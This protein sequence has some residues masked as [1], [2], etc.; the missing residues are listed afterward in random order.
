MTDGLTLTPIG[1]VRSPFTDR[2]C[3]PRQPGVDG[4]SAEGRIVLARGRGFEQAVRDLAGIERIWVITWFHRNE[5]WKPMVL[6]PRG[7]RVKRGVFATR[8]P[9]R[10]NPLG[11]SLLPLR[12]VQGLTL[13]VGELD[14]LDGTPVFDVK[15]YL[16]YAEAFPDARAGWIDAMVAAERAPAFSVRWT[17][18]VTVDL[19]WLQ[20]AHGVTLRDPAEAVLRRDP[21]AHPYR[22]IL[23]DGDRGVLAVRSWRLRFAVE[24]AVVTVDGVE[25]GY[26]PE[27]LAAGDV[28]E[29]AAAHRDFHA[30]VS[31]ATLRRLRP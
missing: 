27:A 7:P 29:D 17:P 18:E 5:G 15:P 1:V 10:P 26:S 6:P 3:A 24:G 21:S 20:E 22:R 4:P 19:A 8:S 28:R 13:H 31:G 14:L 12:R 25:S 11:L 30:R 2:W 9:H 23:R 16:P